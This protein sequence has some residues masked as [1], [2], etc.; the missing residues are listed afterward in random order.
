MSYQSYSTTVSPTQVEERL[1][2]APRDIAGI[3]IQ[4]FG[5]A[6]I[7]ISLIVGIYL[8]AAGGPRDT[9]TG[10]RDTSAAIV[11]GLAT[12]V[13]GIFYG[14]L[15]IGFGRVVIYVR[16]MATVLTGLAIV[17]DSLGG[18]RDIA[19]TATAGSAGAGPTGWAAPPT[20][21]APT[22]S[23]RPP[24]TPTFTGPPSAFGS[25]PSPSPAAPAASTPAPPTQAAAQSPAVTPSPAT[26]MGPPLP[27]LEETAG[28]RGPSTPSFA[29]PTE[30][31]WV[32]DPTVRHEYRY[33]DGQK[34]T[35]RVADAGVE[36]SDPI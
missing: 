2:Q 1:G 19:R 7:G 27:S 33:W 35:D 20:P 34:Y 24:E 16:K 10:E 17:T 12:I 29:K 4:V 15:F 13:G 30:P 21:A 25:P 11:V 8:M 28:G 31:G 22:V 6:I 32:A 5:W 23:P 14:S 26:N 3:V 18:M 36:S 9:F